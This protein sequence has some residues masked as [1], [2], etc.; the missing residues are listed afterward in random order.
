M[1]QYVDIDGKNVFHLKVC[2]SWVKH[3]FSN[4]F[5][6]DNSVQHI[7]YKAS[8]NIGTIHNESTT[9]TM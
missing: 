3:P 9:L 8:V 4:A 5:I 6:V 7:K 2:M 1:N